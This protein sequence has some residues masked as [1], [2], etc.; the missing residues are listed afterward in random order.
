[1][2]RNYYRGNQ[3]DSIEIDYP[4]TGKLE[5]LV[6][7]RVKATG[8]VAHRQGVETGERPVLVVSSIRE[9]KAAIQPIP[10]KTVPFQPVR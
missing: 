2:V 6:N 10:A 9:V 7:K 5:K 8:M 4:N 1:L 3:V